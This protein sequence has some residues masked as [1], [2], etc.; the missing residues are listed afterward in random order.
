MPLHY[1]SC[2]YIL[3]PCIVPDFVWICPSFV[4]CFKP[5]HYYPPIICIV[6]DS[7]LFLILFDV[8]LQPFLC[9]LFIS[10]LFT[11]LPLSVL[12]Q[13][14]FDVGLPFFPSPFSLIGYPLRAS[15]K[16]L[17]LFS[18]FSFPRPFCT[19][20]VYISVCQLSMCV[21]CVL[22]KNLLSS[23]ARLSLI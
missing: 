23:K 1:T 11:T 18:L 20:M 15:I 10:P 22:K 19:H 4:L 5:P 3:H 13:I 2:I 7:V 14:L 9:T 16:L 8:S 6:P 21:I 17:L 12:F